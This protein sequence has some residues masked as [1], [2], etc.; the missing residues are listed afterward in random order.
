[1]IR[2]GIL[3]AARIAP[4]AVIHPASV[5]GD[6]TVRAVAA[7][8]M[9]RAEA[10]AEKYSERGTT[11][12]AFDSYQ[13]VIDHP[14]IDLIY[15]PLPINLHAEWT[16]KALEAG[17]HVLCEKPFAMNIV[18][19]KAMLAAA[20]QSGKRVIEA[21]HYR[22][23]P[24][25]QRLLDQVRAGEIGEMKSIDAVFNVWVGE[26]TGTEIRYLPETGGGAFMDLGCYP[27]SWA[28]MLMDAEP[29]TIDAEARLTDRGVDES[30][31]ATL[32]FAGGAV[33]KL[34]S[35]FARGQPFK[36]ALEIEGTKGSIK[37]D[38]PLAPHAGGKLLSG[39]ATLQKILRKVSR[40]TTYSY[41]ID[42]VV[43]G[44][45]EGTP[46]PT[47]GEAILRQ[48]RTLD[49]IYEAAGLRHLRYR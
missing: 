8:D 45:Q 5:R 44:L 4:K 31:T 28:L 30:L 27:L 20:E 36:A 24:A 3:G 29:E 33:A 35:S 49:A 22:F 39:S 6:V 40:R 19:A 43:D 16:I 10:F 14:D 15:N 2:I 18:E 47:E 11:I 12:E 32:K 46:L 41:M 9:Q 42:A 7:R 13:A 21:F 26:D 1:M 37:F 25:F 38:N 34:Q 23:H 48:Q 17:K